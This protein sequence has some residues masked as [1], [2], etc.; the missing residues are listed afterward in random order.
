MEQ[1]TIAQLTN[2]LIFMVS[3]AMAGMLLSLMLTPIYTLVAYR[4]K[5]W[6]RQ[7]DVSTTGEAL[8][9]F[10]KLHTL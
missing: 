3:L 1:I 7:R 8:T 5:F 10:N 4:Y 2:S 9:V 6:K